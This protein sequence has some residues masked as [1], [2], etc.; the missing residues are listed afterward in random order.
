LPAGMHLERRGSVTPTKKPAL[1][2]KWVCKKPI[3]KLRKPAWL[4]RALKEGRQDLR[5]KKKRGFKEE[6]ATKGLSSV[7][8]I[9]AR[10]SELGGGP[11]IRKKKLVVAQTRLKGKDVFAAFRPT[12]TRKGR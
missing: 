9:Y 2:K 1:R 5:K 8:T 12:K 7:R 11:S 3:G 10:D 6:A 4:S